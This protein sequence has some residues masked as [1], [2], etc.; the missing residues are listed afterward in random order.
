[1]FLDVWVFRVFSFRLV[2]FFTVLFVTFLHS[3]FVSSFQFISPLQQFPFLQSAIHGVD[4]LP[5][6]VVVLELSRWFHFIAQEE[7]QDN[8][9]ATSLPDIRH[10][11]Y[12]ENTKTKREV[13]QEKKKRKEE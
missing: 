3:S 4:N 1:M 5:C 12:P 10:S 8:G 7:K 9:P 6:L 11:H 13:R 2:V